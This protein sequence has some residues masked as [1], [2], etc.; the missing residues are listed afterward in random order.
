MAELIRAQQQ[1]AA[2]QAN[3]AA[4]ATHAARAF[5]N[6]Q[7][8]A[9][10]QAQIEAQGAVHEGHITAQEM[11]AEERKKQQEK[12]AKA[13]AQ[14]QDTPH[15]VQQYTQGMDQQVNPQAPLKTLGT[16]NGE[17]VFNL[18]SGGAGAQQM[19]PL[20]QGG[21]QTPGVNVAGQ[22]FNA[23]ALSGTVTNDVGFRSRDVG[24][25]ETRSLPFANTRTQVSTN[26]LSPGEVL[27]A[28][29][30]Q[31][32]F[33]QTESRLKEQFDKNFML[34][35]ANASVNAAA[36]VAEAQNDAQRTATLHMNVM[37]EMRD[38][39]I[40]RGF[41][42]FTTVQKEFPG[43]PIG[44]ELST[45]LK[46]GDVAKASKLTE[47]KQ[48]TSQKL[49]DLLQQEAKA[50]IQENLSQAA[51]HNA[52]AQGMDYLNAKAKVDDPTEYL[53]GVRG[54][55]QQGVSIS[56]TTGNPRVSTKAGDPIGEAGKILQEQLI[57]KKDGK[58]LY[59]N[60]L[61]ARAVNVKLAP[62]GQVM[63]F[64]TK[65][66][67]G[68]GLFGYGAQE[69]AGQR[70]PLQPIIDAL[71][72]HQ[73]HEGIGPNG[74]TWREADKVLEASGLFRN[75]GT[76]LGANADWTVK[77]DNPYDRDTAQSIWTAA[78]GMYALMQTGV[79]PPRFPDIPQQLERLGAQATAPQP[80]PAA[81]AP[82]P[83]KTFEETVKSSRPA[84]P[85]EE[86]LR[87]FNAARG[88]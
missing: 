29:L 72:T 86:W 1:V 45:A 64:G 49:N 59:N 36:K 16:S 46:N 51:Y 35:S 17:D 48:S 69:F 53:Y 10:A 11:V 55:T 66:E 38:R 25:G 60:P 65:G 14:G 20:A 62:A 5:Q 74:M 84:I 42:T 56:P 70:I 31:Q 23:P 22:Q 58:F 68:G 19:G 43:D 33:G 13:Q 8:L 54:A 75:K 40:R 6:D 76:G 26:D 83:A 9:Q 63:V 80:A 32:Q 85:P 87:R 21:G 37:S 15:P 12:A 52:Q 39:D 79:N 4:Q 27:R 73:T 47:G 71:I 77:E 61:A 78:N 18:V 81:A 30:S 67:T 7:Q 34:Q 41:E 82:A 50:R 24:A 3:A 2:I 88:Q 28:R 57:N 44:V